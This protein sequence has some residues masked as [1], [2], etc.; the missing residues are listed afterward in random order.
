LLIGIDAATSANDTPSHL[1][2]VYTDHAF[3]LA[4]GT[5]VDRRRSG[6][7]EAR[8]ALP[9]PGLPA[10][11]P[12]TNQYGYASADDRPAGSPAAAARA[13]DDAER[14]SLYRQFQHRVVDDVALINVVDFS[15]TTVAST[16]V[17][18][19]SNNPRWATSNWADTTLA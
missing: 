17:G 7:L 12:F 9:V 8:G 19:V 6:D 14:A 1:K 5:R 4:V 15:F 3:D 11:V 10:G 13:V 2:A 18:N 16:R